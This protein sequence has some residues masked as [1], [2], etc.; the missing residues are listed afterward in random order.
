MPT[1]VSLVKAMVFPAVMH[2]C[3]GWTIKKLSA[4]ELMLSNCGVREDHES[5]LDCKEIKPV[6]HKINQ[7]WISIGRTDAEAEAPILLPPNSMSWLI[8]KT[9]ARKDWRQEKGTIEERW[10]DSV[11]NSMDT[12]LS[13]LRDLVKDSETWHP[14]LHVVTKSCTRLSNCTMIKCATALCLNCTYL[15]LKIFNFLKNA[16]H[17]LSFSKS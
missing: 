12:S 1:K 15:N 13:K 9:D 3:E 10:L 16:N 6:N 8:R 7:S 2:A 4:K 11:T 14:A 5:P 17:Y